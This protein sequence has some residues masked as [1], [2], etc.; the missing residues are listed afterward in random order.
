MNFWSYAEKYPPILCR[1]L[2]RRKNGPPYTTDELVERVDGWLVCY[3][4]NS[5]SWEL[6]WSNVKFG[7]M[8]TFLHACGVDFC[9]AGQMN[10]IA[11]YMKLK[12]KFRY[13]SRSPEF[14]SILRPLAQRY[15]DHIGRKIK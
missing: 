10:R 3:E 1:L 11:V 12:G 7:C 13:L 8:H 5:I 14:E 9:N 2:A 6:S 4:I 15:H